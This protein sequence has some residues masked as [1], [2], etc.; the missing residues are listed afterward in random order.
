VRRL[1]AGALLAFGVAACVSVNENVASLSEVSDDAVLLVGKIEIV[2]PIK[3]KD[4]TY[5]A[6]VDLFN[7]KRYFVGRALMFMSERPEYQRH[8]GLA[9]NPPL[10]ET[11]FVKLPRSQRYMV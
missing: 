5:D 4:Q 6:G 1:L 11:F 7:S 10:E 3:A 8:T 2:P 9:L